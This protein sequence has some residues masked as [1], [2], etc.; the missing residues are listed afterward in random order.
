MLQNRIKCGKNLV[1][2]NNLKS[3]ILTNNGHHGKGTSGKLTVDHTLG[4]FSDLENFD[5]ENSN[6]GKNGKDAS[7]S[8]CGAVTLCEKYGTLD[9][10]AFY[11]YD[12]EIINFEE[13]EKKEQQKIEERLKNEYGLIFI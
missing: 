3:L 2:K 4:D 9:S 8:V 5:W 1:F 12:E 7:D 13:K 11:D 6:L 10:S